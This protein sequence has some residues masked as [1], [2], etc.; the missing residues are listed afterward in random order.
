[1]NDSFD[2]VDVS[3]LS[4]AAVLAV[5]NEAFGRRESEAWYQWKHR[6]GPWGA[7]LGAAAVDSDGVIGVRLLLPWRFR[8]GDETVVGHRAT[9]AA[10]V[11]R[12]QGRGVFTAL[13]RWMMEAVPTALI[14]STPNMKS[15][16]GYRKLGWRELAHVP[17]RWELAVRLRRGSALQGVPA[18]TFRTDWDVESLRWRTDGRSGHEYVVDT[19]ADTV[20]AYRLLTQRGVRVVAP[21]ASAGDPELAT[22]LWGRMLERVGARLVLIP[23]SQ[24]APLPRT[25]F[26]WQRGQ[27][28]LLGW[29]PDA[30]PFASSEKDPIDQV[31]W[32]AADLEGVI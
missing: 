27:S 12:A 25:R 6:D 14:F 20:L 19:E 31:P 5:I 11:P 9:E 4:A 30:S 26:A 28:L 7:S 3:E 24:P 8:R 13:N 21:T 23:A 2:I 29:T 17:H 32:T 16:R 1:M 15:R 22:A 18:D 10:T